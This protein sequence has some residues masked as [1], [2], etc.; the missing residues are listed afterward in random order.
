MPLLCDLGHCSR[1][2]VV[3]K[4]RQTLRMSCISLCSFR[5][6]WAPVILLA[7][8][9]THDESVS[10]TLCHEHHHKSFWSFWI[11]STASITPSSSGFKACSNLHICLAASEGKQIQTEEQGIENSKHEIHM[12]LLSCPLHASLSQVLCASQVLPT[13]NKAIHQSQH[14]VSLLESRKTLV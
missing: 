8:A 3:K 2:V 5:Y 13:A 4:L 1:T 11:M 12:S 6:F 10:C 9:D 7:A 14:A